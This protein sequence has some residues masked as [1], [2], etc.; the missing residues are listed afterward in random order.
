MRAVSDVGEAAHR[1]PRSL[2][3]RERHRRFARRS[4]KRERVARSVPL[5]GVRLITIVDRSRLAEQRCVAA[6]VHGPH[7]GVQSAR[8]WWAATIEIAPRL[9]GLRMVCASGTL[10]G[11]EWV[12]GMASRQIVLEILGGEHRNGNVR[13]SDD[14]YR[15]W[16]GWGL[17]RETS[18]GCGQV[19][20]IACRATI[21]M[22][23]RI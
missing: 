14:R 11:I 3:S 19:R 1:S 23:G 15:G 8:A 6:A 21:T 13:V 17:A 9:I 16:S 10:S 12:I 5:D 22:P 2:R 4:R 7:A 18:A 20:V